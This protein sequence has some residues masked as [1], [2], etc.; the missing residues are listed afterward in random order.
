M[1]HDLIRFRM[2]RGERIGRLCSSIFALNRVSSSLRLDLNDYDSVHASIARELGVLQ[3]D[4]YHVHHVND[5]PQDLY[6]AYVEL[7]IAQT[8]PG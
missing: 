3:A 8:G 4:L 6:R 2:H 5:P 7:V 1:T